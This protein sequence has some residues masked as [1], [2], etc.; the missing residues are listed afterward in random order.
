MRHDLIPSILLFV[1]ACELG[2][3]AFLFPP[4]SCLAAAS[5]VVFSPWHTTYAVNG[6]LAAGHAVPF[7]LVV[8]SFR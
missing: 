7:L 3:G 6:P 8:G 1:W 4:A 2:S 5:R